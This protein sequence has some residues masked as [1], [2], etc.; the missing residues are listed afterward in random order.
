MRKGMVG[1]LLVL[2]AWA[3]AWGQGAL[4]VGTQPWIGYG[5]WWV[6]DARGLFGR[7]ALRVQLVNFFTDQDL[8]A[9]LAARKLE[10]ANIA[11][12]TFLLFRNAGTPVK[13]VLLMDASYEADA[14][15]AGPGIRSLQDLR[16]KRVAYEEATTS[17]LLL[18][19]GLR[20]VGLS[21]RDV[22]PV[23]M[24]AKDAGA[25]AVAG[26]VDAAVTY[27]PYLTAAL[28]RG[29]GFRIIYSGRDRPG[30]I[31]DLVVFREEVL[32]GRSEEI[33]QLLRTWDEA[34]MVMRQDPQR[35]RAVIAKAVGS[36]LKELELAFRGVRL[37][38]R[39]DNRRMQAS[40][41]LRRIY[42]DV[43]RIYRELG[44]IRSVPPFERVFDL[45]YVG[46]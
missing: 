36:N 11:T 9:A 4:R 26:R 14:V 15:I 2:Y 33:R 45:R 18:A 34:L 31:S 42:E 6:A 39:A 24:P 44:K 35:S 25:A 1:L 28:Q 29:K 41:E 3:L 40:G 19:Y 20:Q 8:N 30:L 10:G 13:A 23:L 37:F 5:P 27:E 17:E 43:G 21:L 38:T 7:A 46:P 12:H 16:G 32:R 22:Q